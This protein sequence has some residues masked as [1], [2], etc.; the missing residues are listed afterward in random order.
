M[1]Y[2]PLKSCYI[3]IGKFT[4]MCELAPFSGCFGPVQTAETIMC[5]FAHGLLLTFM[6]YDKVQQS[7]N[8]TQLFLTDAV[9]T[10]DLLILEVNGIQS[11]SYFHAQFDPRTTHS[12]SL[13]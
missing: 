6:G 8:D 10:Y 1:Y 7:C 5:S 3:L 2:I 11:S 13:V 4:L 9:I 12:L